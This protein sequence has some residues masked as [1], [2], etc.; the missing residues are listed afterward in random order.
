MWSR[1]SEG[2]SRHPFSYRRVP[3]SP[4]GNKPQEL[5]LSIL[6]FP[7]FGA[8]LTFLT[9]TE[10]TRV[11]RRSFLYCCLTIVWVSDKRF[12]SQ[13]QVGDKLRK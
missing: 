3:C 8:S 2:T 11:L 13:S 7:A 9:R 5:S 1:P 10:E 6:A 4:F 12:K